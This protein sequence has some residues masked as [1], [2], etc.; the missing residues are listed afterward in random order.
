MREHGAWGG[1]QGLV[2]MND[3]QKKCFKAI[4]DFIHD[5]RQNAENLLSLIDI[6]FRKTDAPFGDLSDLVGEQ[7]H[8]VI[9]PYLTS[10]RDLGAKAMQVMY[11]LQ[12]FIRDE[13][14]E[15]L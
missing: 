6:S 3:D 10:R 13:T 5:E 14:G 9:A 4:Y 1:E 2:T 8:L 15:T 12:D 7:L 11:I